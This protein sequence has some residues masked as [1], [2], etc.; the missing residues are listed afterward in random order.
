M[1]ENET[2]NTKVI[3][4][5]SHPNVS[6]STVDSCS[7]IHLPNSYS[8]LLHIRCCHLQNCQQFH[9]KV[10]CG[11]TGD[12]PPSTSITV[13]Q[14]TWQNNVSSLS[15]LHGAKGFVP[16]SDNL[17]CTN[18][19]LEWSSSI[20]RAIKLFGRVE[21]IE[22]SGVVCLYHLTSRGNGTVAFFGDEVF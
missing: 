7:E 19:E 13:R 6:L 5:L 3:I 22:P 9:I 17:S 14:S 4:H 11:S 18:L 1:G 16:S 15:H 12:N 2:K 10:Q 21:S 20:T 8:C